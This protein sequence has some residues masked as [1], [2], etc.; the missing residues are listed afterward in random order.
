LAKST[1]G[2]IGSTGSGKSTLVDI[3]LGLLEAEKGRIEVD[4][5]VIS[6]Q[7]IR[8][9]QSLIGYVPQHIFLSDDTVLANIAFGEEYKDIDKKAAIKASKLANLHSFVTEQLP[10]K[11]QTIVGER[12]IRLSGGERQRIGIARALY[13]NPQLLIFDEAT[14][15]LD[16]KTESAIMDAVNILSKDMTIILIAHRLTTLKKCDSI[17]KLSKGEIIAQGNFD[18]MIDSKDSTAQGKLK[19]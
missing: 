15:A 2:I 1:I 7:N 12:G 11:Y 3:I 10:D 16:S 17:I 6:K 4:G 14:S 8:S 19:I 13:H 18:E 5:K 9:W